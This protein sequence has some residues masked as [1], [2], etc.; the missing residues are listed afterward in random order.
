MRIKKQETLAEVSGAVE[1]DVT[2][3]ADMEKGVRRPSEDILMLLI[4]YFAV[5]EDD[6]VKLWELAGYDAPAADMDAEHEHT[7][8]IV[9]PVIVVPLDARIV[10]TDNLQIEETKYGLTITFLQGGGVQGKTMPVS[11]V[12]MSREHAEQLS[13]TLKDALAP[14]PQKSL[15]SQTDQQKTS[16]PQSPKEK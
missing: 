12:G 7:S 1:I 10:Y 2:N 11:R 14:K 5:G 6:A 16:D 3:L 9:Q 8:T 4:S 13:Q 15:P